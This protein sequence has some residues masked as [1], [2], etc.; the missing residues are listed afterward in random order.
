[1][2]GHEYLKLVVKLTQANA[3]SNKLSACATSEEK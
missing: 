2:E 3:R 1:V